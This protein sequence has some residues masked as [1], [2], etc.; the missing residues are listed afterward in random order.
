MSQPRRLSHLRAG[1]C[2]GER[3]AHGRPV[4]LKRGHLS[5]R[6]ACVERRLIEFFHLVFVLSLSWQ[7][8][9]SFHKQVGAGTALRMGRPPSFRTRHRLVVSGAANLQ[10]V[11]DLPRVV[12][13]LHHC[14]TTVTTTTSR[15]CQMV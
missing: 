14:D 2:R 10:D 7:L 12:E 8:I 3:L 1:D 9:G 5:G 15:V 13:I 4:F 11:V 6:A